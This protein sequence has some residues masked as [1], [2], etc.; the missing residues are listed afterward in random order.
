MCLSAYQ[1]SFN[2]HETCVDVL[3]IKNIPIGYL[4][5]IMVIIEIYS[6]IQSALVQAIKTVISYVQFVD[7]NI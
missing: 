4:I 3:S 1:S 5:N 2:W 7:L 6:Y